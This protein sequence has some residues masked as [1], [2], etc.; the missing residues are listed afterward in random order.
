[1]T[2][3]NV[4]AF[5]VITD[6]R[7]TYI[8]FLFNNRVV[9]GFRYDQKTNPGVI[10]DFQLFRSLLTIWTIILSISVLRS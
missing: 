8:V 2:Y 5:I 9:I 1:M 4:F 3:E 10:I 7:P 6:L